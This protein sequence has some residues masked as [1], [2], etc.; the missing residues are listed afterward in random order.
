MLNAKMP[1][2]D[3][4][5]L[6]SP[7]DLMRLHPLLNI[8]TLCKHQSTFHSDL[9]YFY[10][11]RGRISPMLLLRCTESVCL[12]LC[13]VSRGPRV[14]AVLFVEKRGVTCN[15]FTMPLRGLC[16]SSFQSD[17][18]AMLGFTVPFVVMHPSLIA[19]SLALNGAKIQCHRHETFLTEM[20]PID[21]M[22]DV[23]APFDKSMHAA[24]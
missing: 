3:V 22:I 24:P 7:S 1:S 23:Y 21:E 4:A 19:E 6:L 20:S 14:V 10:Q 15:S 9:L 11:V 2:G 5:V 17:T 8:T 13:Y 16:S 18:G 12:R